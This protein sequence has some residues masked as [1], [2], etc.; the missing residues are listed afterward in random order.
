MPQVYPGAK[1]PF[2]TSVQN[3]GSVVT[4][5]EIVLIIRHGESGEEETPELTLVGDVYTAKAEAREPGGY[6]M[7]H[8]WE[9]NGLLDVVAEGKIWVRRSF[10][11]TSLISDP[12]A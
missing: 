6:W 7:F 2:E 5:P 12:Y 9:T 8:R 3:N 11:A 1:V 10:R 4:A